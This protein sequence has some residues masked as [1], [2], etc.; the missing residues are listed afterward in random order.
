VSLIR[1]FALSA[2]LVTAAVAPLSAQQ[3]PAAARPARDPASIPALPQASLV[4]G[5][6]GSL[7]GTIGREARASVPLASL[8]AYV[9]NAFIAVE[10]KRFWE[11]DGVDLVGVAGAIKGKI[12]GGNRGGASTITQQ[13]VGNL[14]PTVIDRRDVSLGRKLREQQ[15]AREMETRY[16]KRTI[17]ETYLNAI[18]FGRGWYGIEIAARG[19]FGKPASRV[20]L[21]EAATL[22]ALPKGPALYDPARHPARAKERRDLVLTLMTEQ[23][24]VPRPQAEAAKREP[25]ISTP[26]TGFAPYA[27]DLARRLAEGAGIPVRNGGYRVFTT[28]DPALQRA[29]VHAVDTV[30]AE[31]EGR[32][33]W[34]HHTKAKHPKGTTDYLQAAVV[35]LDAQTGDVRALVGGRDFAEAPFNRAVDGLRQP[36]SAFKPV[37]YA[38]ALAQGLSPTAIVGDTALEVQ[39]ENGDWYRP[40][41]ADRTFL[42][43]IPLREALAKSR[44]PVA[45][46]LFLQA[47]AD[48]VVALARRLGIDAPVAPY[49]ASALGAS[50]V[51]PL[52]LVRAYATINNLGVRVEPRLVLRVEDPRGRTVWGQSRPA[53]QAAMDPRLAFLVR[54]LLREP[55]ERGTGRS[56]RRWIPERVPFAGKTG[57]TDAN[58]DVWFVGMTPELVVG[59]WLGFDRPRSIGRGIEGGSLAAPIVGRTLGAWYGGRSTRGWPLVDGVVPVALDRDTGLPPTDLSPPEKVYVEYFVP[60][61]LPPLAQR[62]LLARWLWTPWSATPVL[63]P[64]TVDA[65]P[66]VVPGLPIRP[67]PPPPPPPPD[68]AGR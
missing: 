15:A 35:A 16:D 25:V 48:S 20:T 33:T 24:L 7:I 36:G 32:P 30:T 6:D 22:A 26:A 61:H 34:N 12:T 62:A 53:P 65:T 63:L 17:L 57:T 50:V 67:T 13:L 37:V 3:A 11:H 5:R 45:V 51:Q 68:T 39:L 46:Q 18:H 1:P 64:P 29:A 28:I 2:L 58:T 44:N 27:A 23:G 8:P 21:A 31:L 66:Y 56:A 60:P 47:G 55:V 4:F 52:D 14:H 41:N 43:M 40:Q 42:G 10:D 19:Y 59:A 54:D 38:A 49:P 9:P